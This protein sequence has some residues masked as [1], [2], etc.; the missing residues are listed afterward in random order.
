MAI[1]ELL[2]PELEQELAKTRKTLERL[3]EDKLTFK[4]HDKSFELGALATHLA[5]IPLWGKMTMGS[6]ELD[7]APEGKPLEQPKRI[8]SAA[9]A[10]ARFDQ[11]AAD[12][13]AAVASATDEDFQTEW[14]LKMNGNVMFKMSRYTVIRSMI[15]N[16]LIHHRAQ[17]GV[18]YRLLD[19]PVPAVYGPSAD[20]Q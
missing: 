12:I 8:T 15:L 4:P 19:I 18:Y 7:L 16:H 6:S 14:A 3:P 2:K 17:L 1:S 9:D 13:T 5:T 10:L 20:E 11:H